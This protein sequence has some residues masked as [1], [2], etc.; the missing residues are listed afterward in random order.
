MLSKGVLLGLPFHPSS[1]KVRSVQRKALAN[2]T[3][4][5]PKTDLLNSIRIA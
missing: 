3:I 2:K 5:I 1:R 4:D